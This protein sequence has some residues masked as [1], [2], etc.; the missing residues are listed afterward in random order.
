MSWIYFFIIDLSNPPPLKIYNY[1]LNSSY[2]AFSEFV[3]YFKNKN[4]EA[5]QNPSDFAGL[6]KINFFGV[7]E[8]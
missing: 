5:A 6:K 2:N 3:P 4:S 8:K 1:L 7:N